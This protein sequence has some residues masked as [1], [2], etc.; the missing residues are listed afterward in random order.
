MRLTMHLHLLPRLR[1]S[2]ATLPLPQY[3]VMMFIR[4]TLPFFTM[5]KVKVKFT[6]EQAMKAQTGVEV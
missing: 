6:L 1:M 4:T 5:I 3:A 2:G